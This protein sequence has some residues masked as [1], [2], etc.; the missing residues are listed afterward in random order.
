MGFLERAKAAA[1]QAAVKAKEGVEDI[2]A[3][4]DLGQAYNDLGKAAFEL[5]ES[6]K[7][8]HPDLDA[9]AGKVRALRERGEEGDAPPETEP[10]PPVP[11]TPA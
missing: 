6:G 8:A 9:P 5:I 11:A 10:E 7:I 3:R 4:L 2:Q 1:G